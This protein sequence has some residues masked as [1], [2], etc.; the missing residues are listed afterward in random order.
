M[1]QYRHTMEY[2]IGIKA[3]TLE[4]YVLTDKSQKHNV[5]SQKANYRRIDIAGYQLYKV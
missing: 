1:L 2:Y 3:N 5:E 4:L